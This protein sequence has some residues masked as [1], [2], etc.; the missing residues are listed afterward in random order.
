MK[1]EIDLDELR[2][3]DRQREAERKELLTLRRTLEKM[4]PLRRYRVPVPSDGADIRFALIGDNHAGSLYERFDALGAFLRRAK[5]EGV[6]T[7]LH[8]GDVLDGI[9]IYRGQEFEQYAIGF[10]RQL[11]ALS[12]R[13]PRI[14]G[15]DVRF[16][17]GNHDG[18][19]YNLIG[20]DPGPRIAQATG[21]TYLGRDQ[22]WTELENPEG[23]VL[24][25]MLFHPS[26]GTAYALS[27]RPQ[28][29]VEAIP[30]GKKPDV[31]AIGHYHKAE[32]I[33]SYRNVSVFQTGTFQS[34]TPFMARQGSQ[35]HVGGWI[36]KATLGAEENLTSRITGTFVAFY[37]P[38]EE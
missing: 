8:T 11:Q 37:E 20:A 9:G 35:A 34:Q 17:T 19:F 33:P 2:K 5:D 27:Y 10:D 4:A 14:E 3:E 24:H 12:D 30:G 31:L 15:M 16:I 26:G 38:D 36:V 23:S 7:V 28:K 22:A 32:W 1:D 29:I 6:T 18:S 21:W 13:V 25:V